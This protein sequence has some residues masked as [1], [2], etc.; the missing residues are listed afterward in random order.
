MKI[1]VEQSDTYRPPTHPCCRGRFAVGGAAFAFFEPSKRIRE[2]W[3]LEDA[4]LCIV[5][6]RRV[7]AEEESESVQ[8]RQS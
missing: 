6:I 8:E 2:E 1:C 4:P 7:S 3:Q 5:S